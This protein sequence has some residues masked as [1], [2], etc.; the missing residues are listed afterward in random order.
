VSNSSFGTDEVEVEMELDQVADVMAKP[1]SKQLLGSS[2][3][4]RL[5]YTALDGGPRV[6]PIAFLC[7]GTQLIMCTV[8]KSAKVAALQR[9]PR[10]AITIDTEGMPPHVLLIRGQA[11]IELVDGVPGEF[12][13][14]SRKIVPEEMFA[15]WAAGVRALYQQMAKIT[16]EPD[17]AKLLDFET[18]IP[19]AV[20]DLVKAHGDPRP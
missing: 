6:I 7:A 11:T 18:T 8:P 19:S 16:V 13:E 20:E 14:A 15:D 3:P 1:I 4:A 2:I 5:A 17:W 10:V 12:V 9:N